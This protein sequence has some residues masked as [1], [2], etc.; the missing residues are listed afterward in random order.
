MI[1]YK[2]LQSDRCPLGNGQR[3]FGT[4]LVL[5]A[6]I[7]G[8]WSRSGTCCNG[9]TDED[10]QQ[11]VESLGLQIYSLSPDTFTVSASSVSESQRD[12]F[13]SSRTAK[14]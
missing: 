8:R 9:S 12:Q 11:E 3:L 1:Q 10:A 2:P 4:R 6:M 5:L 7:H 14:S 13:L